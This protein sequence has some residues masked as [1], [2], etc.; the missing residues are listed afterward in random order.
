[1]TSF[2]GVGPSSVCLD[3][4][5]DQYVIDVKNEPYFT[6]DEN[7]ADMDYI[8]KTSLDGSNPLQSEMVC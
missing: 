7:T 3:S 6:I 5:S 8:Y 1:M 2:V 4:T